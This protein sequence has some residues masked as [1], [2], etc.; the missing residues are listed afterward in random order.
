MRTFK[1]YFFSPLAAL[2]II[3]AAYTIFTPFWQTN[4]DVAMS[5]IT[6]GYGIAMYPSSFL[7][8]SNVMWGEIIKYIPSFFGVLGYSWA[9][10]MIIILAMCLVINTLSKKYTTIITI[11]LALILFL[12]PIVYPQFTIISGLAFISAFL[13]YKRYTENN[14]L[15]WLI[16]SAVAAYLSFII[17]IEQFLLMFF[18]A[19]PLLLKQENKYDLRLLKVVLSLLIGMGLSYF[20]NIRVYE[21][22]EWK[23]FFEF[24]NAVSPFVNFN[25]TSILSKNQ[26]ILEANKVSIND[27]Q[28]L[29]GFF[30]ADKELIDIK[31]MQ[32][33]TQSLNYGF[34]LIK[35]MKNLLLSAKLFFDSNVEFF[36]DKN[37]IALTMIL[38]VLM[39]FSP[40]RSL[41]IA[42]FLFFLVLIIMSLIG[43]PGV[44]RVIYPV[45][46]LLIIYHLIESEIHFNKFIFL[47]SGTLLMINSFEILSDNYRSLSISKERY[48]IYELMKVSE[49]MFAMGSDLPYE[50][51]YPVLARDLVDTPKIYGIGSFTWAPFSESYHLNNIG[52]GFKDKFIGEGLH[53]FPNDFSRLNIYCKEHFNGNIEFLSVMM[54]VRALSKLRCARITDHAGHFEILNYL[55]KNKPSLVYISEVNKS[56]LENIDFSPFIS[57]INISGGVVEVIKRENIKESKNYNDDGMKIIILNIYDD[58]HLNINVNDSKK[59]HLINRRVFGSYV[60]Y[61]II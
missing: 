7:I 40:N 33:L 26:E 38:S 13:L 37:I 8:F 61:T 42:W 52:Q 28:L 21:S 10:I 51:L 19:A 25:A 41:V 60:A 49:P 2:L 35:A 50:N 27:I 4:D 32:T 9:S 15:L 48:Q 44:E 46:M 18:I 45:L 29:N 14:S 34:D 58:L 57:T 54:G 43:R 12:R 31:T 11:I 23:F 5:M 47:L 1:E 59:N 30:F 16:A 17:R 24:R 20:Y 55:K 53:V 39:I 56:L 22:D 36:L 6:H 3:A